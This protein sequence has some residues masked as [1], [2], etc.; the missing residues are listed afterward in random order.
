MHEPESLLT[1][2][3]RMLNQRIRRGA[4]YWSCR[5]RS[6]GRRQ[7]WK[8]L[9]CKLGDAG[10]T[11]KGRYWHVHSQVTLDPVLQLYRHQRVESDSV[12]GLLHVDFGRAQL[13]YSRDL[14]ADVGL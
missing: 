10:A 11:K 4:K 5:I 2:R 9:Q 12:D 14:F 1:F 13:E 6:R 8:Q 3:E 7:V